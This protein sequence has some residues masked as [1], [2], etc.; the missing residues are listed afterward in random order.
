MDK[1]LDDW[2]SEIDTLDEELLNVLEKRFDV[3][4]KVG[5]YK[6]QK[7]LPP[8]AEK[9]RQE[10]LQKWLSRA[11]ELNLSEEFVEKLYELIHEYALEIER[12]GK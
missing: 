4:K 11:K 8:L 12:T 7:G 10:V 1:T 2:R 3:V 6:K 9:R 5:K